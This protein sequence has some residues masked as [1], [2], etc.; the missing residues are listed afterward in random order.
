MITEEKIIN[1]VSQA[2]IDNTISLVRVRI[3]T[4]GGYVTSS[5]AGPED[6]GHGGSPPY[7]P[8]DE[9]GTEAKVNCQFSPNTVSEIPL[10]SFR[11]TQ[12]L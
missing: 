10:S 11:K 5:P 9:Q 7:W 8:T 6:N 3:G 12:H 2:S 4:L 1:N